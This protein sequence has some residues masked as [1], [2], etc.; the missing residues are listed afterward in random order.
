MNEKVC[1]TGSLTRWLREAA[2]MVALITACFCAQMLTSSEAFAGCKDFQ[3]SSQANLEDPQVKRVI[4]VWRGVFA[5]FYG[6]TGR[7]TGLIVLSAEATKKGKDG[8]EP[9]RPTAHICPGAPPVVYVTWPLVELVFGKSGGEGS[10]P[11]AFLAFVL[12]HE[13][14]HRIN[15]LDAEGGLLGKAERASAGTGFGVE[16]M[17]D[18]RAA[19]LAAAAGYSMRTLAKEEIVKSF[20]TVELGLRAWTADTRDQM[21]LSTLRSFDAYEG[22]YDVAV[23]MTMSGERE[24]AIRLLARADELIAG[25]GVPLPEV[26]ILRAIALMNAAAPYAP[27]REGL[28]GLTA[29]DLRCAPVFATHTAL[30]EESQEGAVRSG[31][32]QNELI[33]R[34]KA[35]LELAGRLIAEAK[36]YG[37]SPLII[38][39]ATGCLALY[40]GDVKGAKK[41]FDAAKKEA[42]KKPPAALGEAF[43]HNL[44]LLELVS[45]VSKNPAPPVS[46]RSAAK[47]WGKSLGRLG[48]KV[49]SNAEVTA[50]VKRLS[51][52]PSQKLPEPDAPTPGP[53][54]KEK[55][56]GPI[57]APEIPSSPTQDLGQCAEGFTFSHSLPQVGKTES[58]MGITTCTKDV[59]G[60]PGA[61]DRYIRVRLPGAMEPALDPIDLVIMIRDFAPGK[62]PTRDEIAC[63]CPN[64]VPEGVSDTGERAEVLVCPARG[65][66]TGVMMST[67]DEQVTRLIVYE[68]AM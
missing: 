1:L 20:L 47:K 18:K 17:A 63:Q 15:D 28:M 49:K 68:E 33:A 23:A 25:D 40:E 34:A 12:A 35:R 10:Y 60:M 53:M 14:G 32:D 58:K 13:L 50:V 27:W 61:K 9:F 41:A 22:L 62:R 30:W 4:G 36:P 66:I 24:V 19:F 48:K 43:K 67:E 3:G 26:K 51:A 21:L 64:V 31:I 38:E 7:D 8:P 42:G 56:P 29:R 54:C 46:E 5:P 65:M 16:E 39:S 6:M 55:T 52:Y 45:F 2:I 59:E 57:P 11:E 37:V 44:A